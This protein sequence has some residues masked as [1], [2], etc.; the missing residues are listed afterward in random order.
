[1]ACNCESYYKYVC[2]ECQ[3]RRKK[4]TYNE[5]E[6][7]IA[8]LETELTKYK[9]KWQTGKPPVTGWFWIR[10]SS[11]KELPWVNKWELGWPWF[12]ES[13]DYEWAG[14][15]VPPEDETKH[16]SGRE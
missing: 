4:P 13:Q 14:P 2:V 10:H 15:V 1:M 16:P 11:L 9:L 8:A 3:M 5:L 6:S 12:D 7:T